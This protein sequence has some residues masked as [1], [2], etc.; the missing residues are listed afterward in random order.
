MTLENASL[1]LVRSLM[2]LRE[3]VGELLVLITETRPYEHSL[4]YRFEHSTSEI[5]G[6]LDAAIG[7]ALILQ[8]F[9]TPPE[10]IQE[11][12]ALVSCQTEFN[13]V[14]EKLYNELRSYDWLQDLFS[15]GDEHPK[16]W[17]GWATSIKTTLDQCNISVIQDS[18]K[19]CWQSFSVAL[20]TNSL[21]SR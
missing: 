21:Q 2:V 5:L 16:E 7:A 8:Q 1:D 3:S 11:L 12:Q 4:A 17:L 19:N 13:K 10:R 15:L 20:G 6:R 14:T 18:L 9:D